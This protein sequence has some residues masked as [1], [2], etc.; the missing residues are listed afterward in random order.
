[1][2]VTNQ[3]RGRVLAD[4]AETAD[5]SAKRRKGLLGRDKLAE[6][7][8]L[9]ILP[10]ESVHTFGMKFSIDVVYLDRK[11]RIRKL[12]RAMPPW[13]VSAC[14]LAHSVVELPAGVIDRSGTEIG[15]QLNIDAS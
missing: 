15:D 5:T 2:V 7:Y 8:A 3:T 14:L 13:R 6:G 10:C 4:C 11:H 1:M 9:W 12:R